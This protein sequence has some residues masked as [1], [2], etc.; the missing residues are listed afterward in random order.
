MNQT[1]HTIKVLFSLIQSEISGKELDGKYLDDLS[2][3][4]MER[5][6]KITKSHDIAHLLASALNKQKRLVQDEISQKYQ[7]QW[8][9][10]V[11]RYEKINYELKRVS[12]VLENHGIAFLPLKG[13]VLRKYYPEPWM[14]TSCDID[15]LIHPE[16]AET[17]IQ[18]LCEVGFTLQKSRPIFQ[19]C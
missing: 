4:T 15:I 18:V 10:A 12:D 16:D 17:A 19:I 1:E 7:K 11:Y 5:L 2:N 6:Y 8:M 14:R 3:E 9:M 13:S